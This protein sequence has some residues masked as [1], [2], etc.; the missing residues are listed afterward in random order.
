M[1]TTRNMGRPKAMISSLLFA[2]FAPYRRCSSIRSG[3]SGSSVSSNI[4]PVGGTNEEYLYGV[5][6]P[7]YLVLQWLLAAIRSSPAPTV[8]ECRDTRY[9]HTSR[10]QKR[11]GRS[12]FTSVSHRNTAL[13]TW[14]SSGSRRR[15]CLLAEFFDGTLCTEIAHPSR[16]PHE[17]EATKVPFHESSNGSQ[18]PLASPSC[19]SMRDGPHPG[20]HTLTPRGQ[21]Y[22]LI[23]TKAILPC[24][25]HASSLMAR[26]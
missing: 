21:I 18:P 7:F 8:D 2:L 26:K 15:S 23:Q 22:F 17:P 3:S 4:G 19:A 25:A 11:G 13:P 14:K 1:T 20:H 24:L 10:T 5:L 9:T 16:T 12:C 6:S